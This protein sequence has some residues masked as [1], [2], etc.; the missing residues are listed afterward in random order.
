MSPSGIELNSF[1]LFGLLVVTG[2]IGSGLASRTGKI[3]GIT[4][5]LAVGMLMGPSGIGLLSGGMLDNARVFVDISLGL[6]LFQL[7]LLLDLREL[8]ANRAVMG[9]AAVESLFTFC[10][11]FIALTAFHLPPLQCALAAALGV[12]SSPAVLLM[13]CRELDAKGPVTDLALKLVAV[14]NVMAFLLFSAILPI[15]HYTQATA[16]LATVTK[17]LV[18][19]LGSAALAW[20]MAWIM[21]RLAHLLVKPGQDSFSLV[22]GFVML[23]LGLAALFDLSSLLTLLALGLFVRNLET[24]EGLK[25]VQFGRGGEIFF[26]ILFVVAGAN[27]HL[28]DLYAS[29]MVAVAFVLARLVGK[30]LALSL[31]ARTVGLAPMQAVSTGF[32]LIPMAGLAIGLTQSTQDMYPEFGGQLAA[33]VLASVAILETIGPI[34]TEIGLKWAGEVETNAKVEH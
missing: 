10:A 11:I 3:P 13:I 2:L 15:L 5:I 26:L 29:G 27:L 21:I 18:Q 1:L 32:T 8:R 33:I 14:N 19:L 7:G 34:A 30:Q 4:G 22:V 9:M 17:P 23:T 25:E 20:V 28:S 16:T 31:T 6:I 24:H 12:S